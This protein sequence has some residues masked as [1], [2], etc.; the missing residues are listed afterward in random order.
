VAATIGPNSIPLMLGLLPCFKRCG[1]RAAMASWAIGLVVWAT[2]KWGIES[3]DTTLVVALPLATSLLVYVG[4]GLL[5]PERRPEVDE[6]VDSLNSDR[7]ET[8]E[9]TARRAVAVG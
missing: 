3:T 2:V 8:D 6:L 7:D 4:P 1:A 5:L 9:V